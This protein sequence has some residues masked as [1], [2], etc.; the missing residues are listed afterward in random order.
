MPTQSAGKTV[1][2]F[3]DKSDENMGNQGLALAEKDFININLSCSSLV[4][5]S[6]LYGRLELKIH[7]FDNFVSVMPVISK[8]KH[9]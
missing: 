1:I 4:F 3:M 9:Q 8:A 5:N 7:R 6:L 2:D